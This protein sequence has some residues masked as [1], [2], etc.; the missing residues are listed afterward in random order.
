MP[1]SVHPVPARRVTQ[2]PLHHYFGYYDKTPWSADGSRL[3]AMQVPFMDRALTGRETAILGRIDVADS[4][5]F[6]PFDQTL[7]WCWQQGCMLQWLGS[8]PARKVIYNRLDGDRFVSVIRDVE[9]GATRVLPRPVYCV[10][11]DGRQALSLNFAR[12]AVTRPGYGYPALADPWSDRAHPDDDGIYHV[13]LESGE[14]R[15]L[16]SL[17]QAAAVEPA[18]GPGDAK[19]WFNHLEFNPGGTRFSFLHRWRVARGGWTTRLLTANVDGSGLYLLNDVPMTSHYDWRNDRQILAWATR[20]GTGTSYV[21]MDDQSP[22]HEV[23]GGD[24]FHTDG[25]C[26]FSPDRRWVLTDT[27]PNKEHHRTL[28]LYRPESNHRVDIGSFYSVPMGV[29]ELRCD[30]HPR[31]SPDG[32]QVCIDSTHEGTRQMY[33]LDVEPVVTPS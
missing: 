18:T 14:S 28:I 15:L 31:W 21:L 16:I 10:S 2:P 29:S 22:R 26:S 27:Y 3:L 1:T 6:H 8:D 12:L 19:S 4:R 5:A 9:T 23:W 33:V 32:R 17:A 24:I 20:P 13:D 11:R 25:H 7:A 30:L